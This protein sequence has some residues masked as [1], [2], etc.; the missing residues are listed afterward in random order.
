M[1]GSGVSQG[2]VE[3]PVRVDLRRPLEVG[4]LPGFGAKKNVRQATRTVAHDGEQHHNALAP[5]H[6]VEWADGDGHPAA[7]AP[8]LSARS[9]RLFGRP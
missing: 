6:T 5:Q 4:R 8:S 2:W 1:T 9:S 3:L 7:Y